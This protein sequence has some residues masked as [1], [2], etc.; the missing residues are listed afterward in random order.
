MLI[1]CE[2][3]EGVMN[4]SIACKTL[5]FNLAFSNFP[6]C[7]C[8]YPFPRIWLHGRTDRNVYSCGRS[9][10]ILANRY[11]LLDEHSLF[12]AAYRG[13]IFRSIG[14]QHLIHA[15][16]CLSCNLKIRDCDVLVL[17]LMVNSAS[18]VHKNLLTIESLYKINFIALKHKH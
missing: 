11:N 16:N 3:G 15:R 18:S 9:T 6:F 14:F 7:F 5:A 1:L 8:I 4:M 2:H 17:E 13:D 10:G 12:S